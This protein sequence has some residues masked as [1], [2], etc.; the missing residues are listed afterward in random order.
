MSTLLLR[1]AVQTSSHWEMSRSASV[2]M[3]SVACQ[4]FCT[5]SFEKCVFLKQAHAREI[6]SAM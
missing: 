4:L 1:G 2:A 3:I 5:E 6:E